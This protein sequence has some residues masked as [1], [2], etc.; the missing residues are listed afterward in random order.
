MRLLEYQA[1]SLFQGYG[2]RVPSGYLITSG[3]DLEAA[4]A[5]VGIP[6]VLKAQLPVGGRGKAGAILKVMSKEE[7]APAYEKL[8]SLVVSG[9][10]VRQVLAEEYFPHEKEFYCSFFQNRSQRCFSL[11]VTKEGGVEV[12]DVKDKNV[13]DFGLAGHLAGMGAFGSHADR[14]ARVDFCN[15]EALCRLRRFVL[16]WILCAQ[17]RLPDL[18]GLD[19]DGAGVVLGYPRWL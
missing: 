13:M 7:L 12:E 16:R 1:K 8:S 18:A 5:K 14:Q 17:P 3:A 19:R 9:F 6:L 4:A 11:I 2:I 15:P 10:P